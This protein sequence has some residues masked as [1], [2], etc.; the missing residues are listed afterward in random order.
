[1]EIIIII[2]VVILITLGIYLIITKDRGWVEVYGGSQINLAEVQEK[3]SQLKQQGINC[4][5]LVRGGPGRSSRA[6]TAVILVK[7]E[8]VKN[9]YEIIERH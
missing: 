3:Y 5:L 8:E 4:K 7:E 1:M 2:A 6:T 9:A